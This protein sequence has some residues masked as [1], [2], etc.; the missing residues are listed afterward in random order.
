MKDF[1][2]FSSETK[3]FK[4]NNH[5]NNNL[6]LLISLLRDELNEI[7]PNIL[8]KKEADKLYSV[9]LS[10]ENEVHSIMKSQEKN[11]DDFFEMSDGSEDLPDGYPDGEDDLEL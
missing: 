1:T 2:D 10:A 8:S 6:G 9:L 5:N 7:N 11:W 3:D 4:E